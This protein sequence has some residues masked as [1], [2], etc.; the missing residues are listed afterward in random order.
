MVKPAAMQKFFLFAI[1]WSMGALLELDDRAKMEEF[2]LKHPSKFHYPDLKPG[3][4]IFEYGVDENGPFST[5]FYA[6]LGFSNI[7]LYYA[8]YVFSCVFWCFLVFYGV[9]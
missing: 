5:N 2:L 1:M 6:F 8:F 3:E 9:L 7:F 4:T